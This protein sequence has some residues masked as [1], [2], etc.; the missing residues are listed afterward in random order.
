MNE[1]YNK[2]LS[3]N[4][5]T[6][7]EAQLLYNDLLMELSPRQRKYF[8]S[9]VLNRPVKVNKTSNKAEYMRQYRKENGFTEANARLTLLYK[10]E[11]ENSKV[12]PTAYAIDLFICN[13]Q[14]PMLNKLAEVKSFI[15]T[16]SS[17]EDV[18]LDI[19]NI[20]ITTEQLL[21][22]YSCIIDIF[23]NGDSTLD[24]ESFEYIR[25]CYQKNRD[26]QA[27]IQAT[28]TLMKKKIFNKYKTSTIEYNPAEI[29]KPLILLYSLKSALQAAKTITYKEGYLYTKLHRHSQWARGVKQER[30]QQEKDRLKSF[31][32]L[33]KLLTAT[34]M[35]SEEYWTSL[36]K[37][38]TES[39]GYIDDIDGLLKIKEVRTGR[40]PTRQKM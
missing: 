32:E 33:D 23:K 40:K 20:Y 3:L 25:E 16:E 6:E 38:L 19:D 29:I 24:S 39:E 13:M 35:S 37:E 22:E 26:L 12:E 15:V 17:L 21:H 36:E 34:G 4:N 28:I 2:L 10:Q 9:E 5:S 8:L 27:S 14:G 1:V 18:P 30:I 7:P 11:K 31:D